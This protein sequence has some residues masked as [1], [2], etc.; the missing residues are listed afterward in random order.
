MKRELFTPYKEM[1]LRCIE[2]CVNN[3]QLIIC[4]DMIDRFNEQF[5]H[6][7]DYRERTDAIDELSALYLQKQA[8]L[9]V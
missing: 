3:D 1:I 4:H 6:S 5:M 8:E 9:S 7:V 2:S